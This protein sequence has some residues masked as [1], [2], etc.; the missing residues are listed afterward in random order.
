MHR[1]CT[2]V[3]QLARAIAVNKDAERRGRSNKLLL[4]IEA[5]STGIDTVWSAR[6]HVAFYN[7]AKCK[8]KAA[9]VFVILFRAGQPGVTDAS[10][11]DAQRPRCGNNQPTRLLASPTPANRSPRCVCS[12]RRGMAHV[13][14]ADLDS[15][16]SQCASPTSRL[17]FCAQFL[18]SASPLSPPSLSSSAAQNFRAQGR[19]GAR[20]PSMYIVGIWGCTYLHSRI[21]H[22][23]H[24]RGRAHAWG[25]PHSWRK[26]S[27]AHHPWWGMM[28]H[29]GRPPHA[30]G[31][32]ESRGALLS[33]RGRVARREAW[34]RRWP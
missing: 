10:E 26:H 24:A 18:A 9:N 25:R 13:V 21:H 5:T 19:G 31:W 15:A 20:K 3:V 30:W 22:R 6:G 11:V 2:S 8:G 27:P 32:P 23:V 16:E 28:H 29:L 33:A 14:T 1:L 4:G 7:T 17:S 12:M 34:G